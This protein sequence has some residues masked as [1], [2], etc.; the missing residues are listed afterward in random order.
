MLLYPI[1]TIGLQRKII[2]FPPLVHV[3]QSDGDWFVFLSTNISIRTKFQL[4]WNV[5]NSFIII[6]RL[7]NYLINGNVHS[8]QLMLSSGSFFLV[9]INVGAIG[10][11][12]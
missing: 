11:L 8:V 9:I 5:I 1:I 3:F 12:A 6:I 10:A 2:G 4:F 7:A